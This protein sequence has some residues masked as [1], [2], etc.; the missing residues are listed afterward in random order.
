MWWDLDKME[1]IYSL[2]YK[3]NNT[4]MDDNLMSDDLKD[5]KFIQLWWVSLH[6][7]YGINV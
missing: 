4:K 6:N 5:K 2:Q 1:T 3:Q 7:G